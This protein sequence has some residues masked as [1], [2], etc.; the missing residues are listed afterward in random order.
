MK[1]ENFPSPSLSIFV[2]VRMQNTEF[3]TGVI[4]PVE[5]YK[6]AWELIKG[7]Y[8][9]LFA[10]TVLGMMIGGATMY[11][12]LGAMICGIFYCYFQAI[13]GKKVELEGLF[14]GF[15][16]FLPGLLVTIVI[17]APM[18]VEFAIIYVPLIVTALGGSRI[19]EDELFAIL[20]AMFVGVSIISVIM[21]CVHTLLMFA[22]PLIVDKNLSA[23]QA[24]KTSARAVWA[25]LSGVVG[26]FVV[27]F[28]VNLAGM[29]AA[30]IGVYLVIPLILAANV[31][32]YRKVF[33]ASNVPPPNAF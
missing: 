14:K 22:F 10:I 29:L 23:W 19:S 26:L 11:V 13:D 18:L 7:Q 4:R 1:A 16:Y 24:M 15:G 8:W 32:A 33:P 28:V 30:C 25:N 20:G 21:V 3:R 2:E 17:V 27:G 6:E 9:L 12:L 31:V 5:C